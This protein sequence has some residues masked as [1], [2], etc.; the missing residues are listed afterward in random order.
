M[1]DGDGGKAVERG[2]AGKRVTEGLGEFC[3]ASHP[4]MGRGKNGVGRI[5][6]EGEGNQP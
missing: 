5:E 6:R 4:V 2:A 1:Y 3:L